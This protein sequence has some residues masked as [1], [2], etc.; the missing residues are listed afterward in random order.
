MLEETV[1]A[2]SNNQRSL[3]QVNIIKSYYYSKS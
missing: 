2:L 1:R 3:R